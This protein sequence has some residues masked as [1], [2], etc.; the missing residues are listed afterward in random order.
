MVNLK[1]K[2]ISTFV[3]CGCLSLSTLSGC[4]HKAIS[5]IHSVYSMSP[6]ETK[7]TYAEWRLEWEV[8]R[9]FGQLPRP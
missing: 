2:Q 3:L 7:T 9:G 5:P 1:N 6:K 8:E 4:E